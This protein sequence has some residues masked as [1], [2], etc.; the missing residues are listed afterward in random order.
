MLERIRLLKLPRINWSYLYS[1]K[2]VVASLALVLP[3]IM[4][5][6]TGDTWQGLVIGGTLFVAVNGLEEGRY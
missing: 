3:L 6:M 5:Y 1:Q 4:G 2:F